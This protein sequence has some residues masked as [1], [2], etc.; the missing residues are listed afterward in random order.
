MPGAPLAL[1]PEGYGGGMPGMPPGGMP[2]Q[3][4]MG[5]MPPMPIQGGYPGQGMPPPMY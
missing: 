5:G 1:M 2:P 3:M 4:G